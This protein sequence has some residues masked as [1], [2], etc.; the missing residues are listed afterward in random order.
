MKL[1]VVRELIVHAS[2]AGIA[3][4]SLPS[5]PDL[6][7]RWNSNS[8]CSGV[9]GA[10]M[11][12]SCHAGRNSGG[13]LRQPGSVLTWRQHVTNAA[14]G[15]PEPEHSALSLVCHTP[16]TSFLQIA[17]KLWHSR[18]LV[19]LSRSSLLLRRAVDTSPCTPCSAYGTCPS[20]CGTS[21]R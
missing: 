18:G 11:H 14:Y 5:G 1:G 3:L 16:G 10:R 21:C 13:D 20:T 17:G 8:R 12:S 4:K 15:M 9:K 19:E 7:R 2:P 6:G